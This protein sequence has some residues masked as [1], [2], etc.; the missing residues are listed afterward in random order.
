MK[1]MPEIRI[2]LITLLLAVAAASPKRTNEV[3]DYYW[4]LSDTENTLTLSYYQPRHVH[5]AY[6]DTPTEMII[7]WS[8]LSDPGESTV[9]FG[10][11]KLDEFRATG[12]RTKF[13]DAGPSKLTQFIHR[14]VLTGLTPGQRYNY[15]C[16]SDSGWSDLFYFQ[17]MRNDSAW[18]PHLAIYGDLGSD[19]AQS[20][21][22]LQKEVQMGVYDAIVHVGDFAYDMN[23]VIFSSTCK[24]SHIY[25]SLIVFK[26]ILY[27]FLG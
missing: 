4:D 15:H 13:V 17:A 24:T 6:S 14:V 11:S 9:E 12:N 20:M 10:I 5:L 19:N 23:S 2:L 27:F 26:N 22:R 25:L 3:R 18:L 16:G 7:T 21:S 8:T 1:K